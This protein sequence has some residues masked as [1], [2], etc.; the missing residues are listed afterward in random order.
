MKR[1]NIF[2]KQD[3]GFRGGDNLVGLEAIAPTGTGTGTTGVFDATPS[4]NWDGRSSPIVQ[5]VPRLR[6]PQRC[7]SSLVMLWLLLSISSWHDQKGAK[8]RSLGLFP[9]SPAF[10]AFPDTRDTS[11]HNSTFLYEYMIYLNV[12]IC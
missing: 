11:T 12:C 4:S 6:A 1:F 3:V 7:M 8:R 9:P 10:G 5:G 2:L